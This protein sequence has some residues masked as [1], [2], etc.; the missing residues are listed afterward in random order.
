MGLAHTRMVHSELAEHWQRVVGSRGP[1]SP[2]LG[3]MGRVTQGCQIADLEPLSRGGGE[4]GEPA[5][6]T[7][8]LDFHPLSFLSRG[9]GRR[10]LSVSRTS[11]S[12]C[13]IQNI[14]A[15]TMGVFHSVRI[16][17]AVCEVRDSERDSMVCTVTKQ[18]VQQRRETNKYNR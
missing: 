8:F 11:A 16:H 9:N 5:G 10:H 15:I 3:P 13:P 4:K 12:Q 17:R 1:R 7:G 6:E 2:R 18:S 14:P